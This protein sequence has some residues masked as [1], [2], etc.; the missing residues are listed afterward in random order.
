MSLV[1]LTVTSSGN[2]SSGSLVLEAVELAVK[3]HVVPLVGGQL[4]VL[5]G[6][7]GIQ[8]MGTEAGVDVRGHVDGRRRSVLGPVGEIT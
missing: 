1:F 2:Y 3:L 5:N 4:V 7:E 6:G 8:Q